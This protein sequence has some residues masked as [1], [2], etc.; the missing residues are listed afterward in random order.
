MT[1]YNKMSKKNNN[2]KAKPVKPVET[3]TTETEPVKPVETETTE[4][5][6]TPETTETE[7]TKPEAIDG[8]VNCTKLYVRSDATV[9]SEPVGIIDRGSEVFIYEDESTEEFYKVCAATGLEG[10]CMKKFISVQ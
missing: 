1:N 2:V 3:E 5:T 9:D 8:V 6:E 7:P 4:T 10:Y